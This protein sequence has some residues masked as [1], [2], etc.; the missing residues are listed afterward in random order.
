MTRR[1]LVYA[2]VYGLI[3]VCVGVA[4]AYYTKDLT[5]VGIDLQSDGQQPKSIELQRGPSKVVNK[6]VI[7]PTQESE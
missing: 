6:T 5:V 3:G 1:V 4:M 2:T 7:T